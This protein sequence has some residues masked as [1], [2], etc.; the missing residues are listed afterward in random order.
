VNTV[1]HRR[2]VERIHREFRRRRIVARVAVLVIVVIAASAFASQFTTNRVPKAITIAVTACAVPVALYL[3][4]QRA[5]P[6]G[7][8]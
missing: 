3:G 7:R 4:L 6:D 5:A 2:D 1:G 8:R